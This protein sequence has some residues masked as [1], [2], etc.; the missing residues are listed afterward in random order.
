M[1]HGTLQQQS[2]CRCHAPAVTH[3]CYNFSLH[4]TV[5]VS[6]AHGL[7]DSPSLVW[8]EVRQI[9]AVRIMDAVG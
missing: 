8:P 7:T 3:A 1:F 5:A 6:A 4:M 2:I 9:A